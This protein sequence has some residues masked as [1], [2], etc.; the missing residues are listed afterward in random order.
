MQGWLV[1]RAF[2]AE[3]KQFGVFKGRVIRTKPLVGAGRSFSS[4]ASFPSA[5]AVLRRGGVARKVFRQDP[6]K[7]QCPGSHPAARVELLPQLRL[8][9]SDRRLP[10]WVHRPGAQ[11][12]VGTK[13]EPVAKKYSQKIKGE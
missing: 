2:W 10:L 6:V 1:G 9:S 13:W 4:A 5:A 11:G 3:I 12:V 7:P 8:P